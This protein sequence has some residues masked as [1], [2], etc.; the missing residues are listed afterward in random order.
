M[1]CPGLT[2]AVYEIK[3]M[4]LGLIELKADGVRGPVKRAR[5]QLKIDT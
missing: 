2:P 3:L 4:S 1:S 5:R